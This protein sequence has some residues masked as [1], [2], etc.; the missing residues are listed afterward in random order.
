MAVF[1]LLTFKA[2]KVNHKRDAFWPEVT[3]TQWYICLL[4]I[5][6]Y[7]VLWLCVKRW[8]LT[9]NQWPMSGF[10]KDNRSFPLKNY[11]KSPIGKLGWEFDFILFSCYLGWEIKGLLNYEMF[12]EKFVSCLFMKSAA[13][14]I[15]RLNDNWV[16][17]LNQRPDSTLSSKSLKGCLSWS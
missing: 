15:F 10:H 5:H 2:I 13:H 14:N 9:I 16:P 11:L 4:L 12:F 8:K 1:T 17:S 3:H 6:F 7:G